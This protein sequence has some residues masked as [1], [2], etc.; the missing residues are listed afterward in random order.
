MG[1]HT[2]KLCYKAY[3][4]KNRVCTDCPVARCF[5][6]GKV[7][8]VEKT[9]LEKG[10]EITVEITASPIK[11]RKGKITAA[12]EVVR[13]ITERKHG[14]NALLKSEKNFKNL[15]ENSPISLWVYPSIA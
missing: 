14:E 10:K 12:V 11:D 6:D 1:D 4:K 3:Q 8:R 5:R 15:F 2:G 9:S 13:D 7:H